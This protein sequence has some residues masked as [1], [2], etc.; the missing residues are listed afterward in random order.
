MFVLAVQNKMHLDAFVSSLEK[1]LFLEKLEDGRYDDYF[2]KSLEDLFLEV[3]GG[4]IKE[5]AS[6]GIYNDAYWCGHAYFELHE[7]LEK[8]F[9]YL[10]LKL[11]FSEL[12]DL[13]PVYHEMDVSSLIDFFQEKEKK[14]T[15]LRIL[16]EKR[17]CSIAK[18]SQ[19]TNIPITTLNKYNASDDALYKASFQNVYDIAYFFDAPTSLFAL[20][21]KS[22]AKKWWDPP[23]HLA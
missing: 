5:D 3:T 4:R 1:S 23:S 14:K 15:V 10:F 2:N 9:P 7:R 13:Y 20:K 12:M 18:L 16:C 6:Y 19:A 11:P 8:P 22:G 17:G 21:R